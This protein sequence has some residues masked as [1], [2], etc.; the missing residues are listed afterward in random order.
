MSIWLELPRRATG[1]RPPVSAD[2][3]QR[4]EQTLGLT[5]PV[6]FRRLYTELGDGGWGP[7][8]GF[9]PLLDSG[10]H[11]YVDSIV[12]WTESLRL[13]GHWPWSV[14]PFAYWGCDHHSLL[15]VETGQ[16][17]LA[18]LWAFEDGVPVLWQAPSLEA[19]LTS[20]LEGVNLFYPP[21]DA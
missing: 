3:F 11:P 10:E 7:S 4:A 17:G 16:V 20:W 6:T 9:L 1:G 2:A 19:W 21:E 13:E 8:Y 18:P 15:N 5:F 14:V 12:G